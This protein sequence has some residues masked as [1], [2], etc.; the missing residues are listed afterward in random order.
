MS[1]CWI[2]YNEERENDNITTLIFSFIN[3]LS[4]SFF[5]VAWLLFLPT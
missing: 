1:L 2:V 5:P 4:L 3:Y